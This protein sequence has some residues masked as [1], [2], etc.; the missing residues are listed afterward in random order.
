[1]RISIAAAAALSFTLTAPQAGA[2]PAASLDLLRRAVD[3]NPTLNS[4]TASAQLS[5]TLHVLIPVN[6]N[7][8]GTVYYLRPR[9]KIE[10]ENVSGA[11]SRFK[12]L[13]SQT[14][15]YEQAMAEYTI[16]PLRDDG[17]ISTYSLVPKKPGGRVKSVMLTVTD[18]TA[19]IARAQWAYSNGGSLSFDQNYTNVGQYRLPAKT[20][21]AARFPGYSVDGT[22]TFANY[23][24]NATV[25][26]SA[27]AS[28]NPS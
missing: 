26:P 28:P 7:F 5:A 16:A 1:M 27:F 20:N 18:T 11:L 8:S 10:F 21:I 3:P 19:L 4:Y 14:P 13:A 2:A 22:L 24:P 25:S 12:D 15:S 23:Q 9:R 17:T 6:K